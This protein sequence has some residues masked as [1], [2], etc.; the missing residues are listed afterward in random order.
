MQVTD[1]PSPAAA[2][3]R[4]QIVAAAVEVLADLGYARTSFARIAERA[5]ISSTRLISYH[6]A[7]KDDLMRAVVADVLASA[8]AFMAPRVRAAGG[9]WD[10][11]RV[12][13]ESNL[14]FLRDHPADLRA[15]TEVLSNLRADD[16]DEGEAA[17]ATPPSGDAVSRLEEGFLAGQRGG[18]F[19]EFDA[20]VMARTLRA[21][22]DAAAQQYSGDPGT[23]LDRYADELVTLFGLAVLGRDPR[24]G[25]LP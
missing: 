8:E 1:R 21:A 23:D 18:V 22:I 3:R 14:E 13:I 5:G 7:G 10:M 9:H 17:P 20:R 2:A 19:R 12:Y 4:A 25:D 11:L 16:G 6:F 15:L 24:E